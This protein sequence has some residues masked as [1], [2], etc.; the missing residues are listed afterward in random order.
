MFVKHKGT[1][2]TYEIYDITYDANGYP[3]FLIYK[4]TE[5]LGSEWIRMSAKHFVPIT[6]VEMYYDY[7]DDDEWF[8]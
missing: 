3:H 4:Y 2:E 6:E 5:S 8:K 7:D 1:G